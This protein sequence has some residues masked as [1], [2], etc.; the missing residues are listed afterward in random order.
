MIAEKWRLGHALNDTLCHHH[1]PDKAKKKNRQ[2]TSIV[3]LG[4]IYANDVLVGPSLDGNSEKQK[5]NDLLDQIG[6][7]WSMLADHRE[8]ILDELENAKIFLQV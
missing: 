6:I 1:H 7:S 2:L 5:A 3:A 4:N 8:T